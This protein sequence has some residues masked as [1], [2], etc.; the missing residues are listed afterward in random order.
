MEENRLLEEQKNEMAVVNTANK[1]N[2]TRH[3]SDVRL[4]DDGVIVLKQDKGQIVSG[5][6]RRSQNLKTLGTKLNECQAREDGSE[7]SSE[8][9]KRIILKRVQSAKQTKPE[10]TSK[11]TR[12]KAA[13]HTYAPY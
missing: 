13:G 2:R 9:P 4:K 8:R 7:V 3:L 1:E 11:H 5:S 6:L 10:S 12:Q